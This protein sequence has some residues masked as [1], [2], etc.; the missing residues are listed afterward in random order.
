M[1]LEVNRNKWERISKTGGTG[2]FSLYIHIGKKRY[3]EIFTTRD[4]KLPVDDFT[5]RRL[6]R[7]QQLTELLEHYRLLYGKRKVGL[8]RGMNNDELCTLSGLS[9]G[10]I[11]VTA[12]C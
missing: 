4:E 9:I 8:N 3:A 11:G 7:T 5:Y 2:E 12:T 1:G 10:F 6:N